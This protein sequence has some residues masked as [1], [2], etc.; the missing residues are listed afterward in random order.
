MA[1]RL[2][3]FIVTVDVEDSGDFHPHVMRSGIAEAL[4]QAQASGDLLKVGDNSTVVGHFRVASPEIAD[5]VA[6]GMS[7]RR[8]VD[9][10]VKKVHEYVGK[11]NGK[12][13]FIQCESSAVGLL[14]T[15]GVRVRGEYDFEK[16]GIAAK[17]T[18]DGLNTLAQFPAD[19]KVQVVEPATSPAEKV[20]TTFDDLKTGHYFFLGSAEDCSASLFCRATAVLVDRI[21][22]KCSMVAAR[23][24]SRTLL[25]RP[26]RWSAGGQSIC[27]A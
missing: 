22:G 26:V 18:P 7:T 6:P 14:A 23:S 3:Q 1:K 17:V 8:T 19:F 4:R 16:G 2:V 12:E 25:R 15:L 24:R 5:L 11:S 10:I 9:A 20:P 21:E 13:A 27:F